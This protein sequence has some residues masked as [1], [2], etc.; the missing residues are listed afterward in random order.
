MAE[1]FRKT[2]IR[3]MH[4]DGD[5]D[6]DVREDA[7]RKLKRGELDILVNVDLF[8]EGF[9][10]PNIYAVYDCAAT[11]SYARFA[12]RFGRMLRLDILATLMAVWE[13]LTPLQRKQF[14]AESAKPW[15]LYVDLVG[16]INRHQGTPDRGRGW[17]LESR[18]SKGTGSGP[19]MLTVC[20]NRDRGDGMACGKSYARFKSCCPYCGFRPE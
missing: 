3:A 7:V 18:A 6:D 9:D 13:D 1:Q 20:S 17:S 5:T 10:L 12:Q 2:V 15:G 14:I 19:S 11:A 8:G 16:N 4:V